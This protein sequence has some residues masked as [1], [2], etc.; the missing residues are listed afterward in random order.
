MV[1]LAAVSVA[2]NTDHGRHRIAALPSA[3]MPHSP[4]LLE[5]QLQFVRRRAIAAC[6]LDAVGVDAQQTFPQAPQLLE[7]E[8]KSMQVPLQ[9]VSTC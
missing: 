7:S 8:F 4:Q 5:S 1:I 6:P 9:D 3:Y 2:A